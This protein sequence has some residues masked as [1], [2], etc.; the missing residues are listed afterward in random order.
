MKK[1]LALGIVMAALASGHAMA[2]SDPGD[3]QG[4]TAQRHRGT[5]NVQ[6]G[7]STS[8]QPRSVAPLPDPPHRTSAQPRC[9]AKCWSRQ[10][11]G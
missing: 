3:P 11:F 10:V 9:N 1:A 6:D 2:Q 7:G 8:A 5:E 4:Y